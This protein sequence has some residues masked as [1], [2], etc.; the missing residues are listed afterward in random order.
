MWSL[1]TIKHINLSS[2]FIFDSSHHI[3]YK[4]QI[5]CIIFNLLS[6]SCHDHQR[7]IATFAWFA[8]KARMLPVKCA[9]SDSY[10]PPPMGA[11]GDTLK[12]RATT[13]TISLSHHHHLTVSPVGIT[14]LAWFRLHS[15]SSRSRLPSPLLPPFDVNS[16]RLSS[17]LK[18]LSPH[19]GPLRNRI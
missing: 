6:L 10:V 14:R 4:L 19:W 15:R 11:V 1:N 5:I 2:M 13:I 16:P 7:E 9:P 8:T 17:S 18:L 12:D 3:V